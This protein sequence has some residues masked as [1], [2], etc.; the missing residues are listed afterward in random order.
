LLQTIKALSDKL[1]SVRNSF[2]PPKKFTFKKRKNASAISNDT[3]E[4]V[5]SQK[6]PASTLPDILDATLSSTPTPPEEKP[7]RAPL[8]SID[9]DVDDGISAG[10]GIQRP[11]FSKATNVTI[12]KHEGLRIILPTSASHATSSGTVANLK[13][14]VVDL[15]PPTA[16]GAP[17]AALYLKNIKDSLVICGQVAGAIHITNI[18]NSVIVTACQQFRMH[19]SRNVDIYLHSAS[20]PIFEDCEGLRFAPLPDVYVSCCIVTTLIND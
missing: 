8:K 18:E 15:S 6:P 13:R 16:N 3:A 1:Q 12:S 19:G 17:F 4:L 2:N 10:T 5:Q 14:C 20:R 7:Q 11:S 9:E